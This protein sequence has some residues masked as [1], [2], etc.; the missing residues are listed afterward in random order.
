MSDP[1]YGFVPLAPEVRRVVRDEARWD[2]RVPGTLAG[3]IDITLTAEQ[4]L[5]IG[6]G[7]KQA[8]PP[9]VI[10]RGA[11]IHGRP[12]IPGS[13]LKGVLRARYEAITKSCT[14][15]YPAPS[16]R[17]NSRTGIKRARLTSAALDTPVLDDGCTEFRP[18]PACALFGRMSLR[19]RVTV[20][21]LG[22]SGDADFAL[23]AL[24]VR[25]GPNLHHVGPARRT[26]SGDAF[27]VHGLHGRKFHGGRGPAAETRARVEAIRDG[28]VLAGQV[29]IFNAT[30]AELGGLLVALGCDPA[31]ALKLGG[32]KAHGAGRAQ[33][34][35]TGH[36]LAATGAP[37]SGPTA[38]RQQF[39]DSPDRW[40][41]GEARLVALHR[42][43]C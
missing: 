33:C 32:G 12:G 26:P 34:R 20:T 27:E 38:W 40:A 41:D 25:F 4:P 6:S 35:I 19:S 3:H 15:L 36:T 17:I 9:H 8:A 31:S 43:A 39:I 10:L 37:A 24:P 23:V 28:T 29:R 1:G 13:S 22:S 18:C 11:R 2:R 16:A 42:G 21:D 14:S 5:H 7:S 30:P